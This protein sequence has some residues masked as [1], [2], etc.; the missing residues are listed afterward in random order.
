MTRDTGMNDRRNA[1]PLPQRAN[2]D[3]V[4]LLFVLHR[5]IIFLEFIQSRRANYNAFCSI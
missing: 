5:H 2:L 3:E 4:T 1:R